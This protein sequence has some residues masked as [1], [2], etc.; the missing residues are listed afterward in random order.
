M[1]YLHRNFWIVLQILHIYVRLF[2]TSMFAFA[3]DVQFEFYTKWKGTLYCK[4]LIWSINWIIFS[5]LPLPIGLK[6]F[7]FWYYLLMNVN[8][9]RGNG[10]VMFLERSSFFLIKWSWRFLLAQFVVQW[11]IPCCRGVLHLHL[12]FV[13]IDM[14]TWVSTPVSAW[15]FHRVEF[16]KIECA[17]GGCMRVYLELKFL[18][19]VS[20]KSIALKFWLTRV[21]A[22]LNLYEFQILN[23]LK[24]AFMAWKWVQISRSTCIVL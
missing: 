10:F 23:L 3:Y 22:W 19:P 12:N 9:V 5:C 16:V 4:K 14:N 7:S 13:K 8:F 1:L 2:D 17:N 6:R 20:F 21:F 24:V 18:N 11:L 15:N